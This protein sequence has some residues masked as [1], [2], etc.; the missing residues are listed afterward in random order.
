MGIIKGAAIKPI[1]ALAFALASGL[2]LAL[3]LPPFD[4]E[5]LG[6]FALA[7]LFVAATVVL[8]ASGIA[9]GVLHGD[10]LAVA[11]RLHGPASVVWLVLFGVHAL[12]YL[13]R[14][15]TDSRREV[16][17][18]GPSVPGR[19]KRGYVIVAAVLAGVAIGAATVP[20][21]HRWVRLQRDHRRVNGA[22]A[23]AA[24]RT[25][26]SRPRGPGTLRRSG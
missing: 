9:M 24:R 10:S 14:A 22:G 16:C 4:V 18:D 21:Q 15:L 6:W 26:T 17:A 3:S 7:P 2:L 5:W 12:V 25:G 23:R 19:T 8:F 13:G 11:R 1:K 20:A